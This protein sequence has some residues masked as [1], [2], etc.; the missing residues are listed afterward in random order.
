MKIIDEKMHGDSAEEYINQRFLRLS[1]V[2]FLTMEKYNLCANKI[3]Y[4]HI[5]ISVKIEQ[6][7]DATLTGK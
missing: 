3:I 1:L 7:I 5:M 4:K 2:F 6:E